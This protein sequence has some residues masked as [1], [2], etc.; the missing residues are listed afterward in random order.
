MQ[1]KSNFSLPQA[2]L[3]TSKSLMTEEVEK[4]LLSFLEEL[5]NAESFPPDSTWK[6]PNTKRSLLISYLPDNSVILFLPPT[7][8]SSTT[9][10]QEENTL[11]ENYSD[12]STKLE[13]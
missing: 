6:S 12:F 11:E 3:E 2:T 4:S 7:L 5:I 10:E 1:K 8:E 9:K 13:T